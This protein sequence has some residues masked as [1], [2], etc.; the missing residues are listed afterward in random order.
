[1]K[2]LIAVFLIIFTLL[3]LTACINGE[4]KAPEEKAEPTVEEIFNKIS[5]SVTLPEEIT[6]LSV[7][8]LEDYYGITSDMVSE[9]KAIQ[10]ASGYQDEI[11][12]IK[13]TSQENAVSISALLED[14]IEYSKEQMR[15]YS[16]EQY[17]ILTKSNVIVK[18]LFV[19][20]FVSADSAQMDEIFN[21]Y[22]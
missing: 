13:A 15:D 16:P 5:T 20:M 14:R 17:Q 3:S 22:F 1:M 18:G 12:I 19:S 9:F 7:T 8:D 10:N 2:K 11:V 4:E 6:E 21:S